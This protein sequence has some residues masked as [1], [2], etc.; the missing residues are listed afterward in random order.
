MN[1][2]QLKKLSFSLAMARRGKSLESSGRVIRLRQAI[3]WHM[4]DNLKTGTGGKGNRARKR[5]ASLG[6]LSVADLMA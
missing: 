2:N 1:K 6:I 4:A 3:R 5:I